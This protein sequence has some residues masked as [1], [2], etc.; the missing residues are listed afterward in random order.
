MKNWTIDDER[1]FKHHHLGQSI[2]PANQ[3]QFVYEKF[4]QYMVRGYLNVTTWANCYG[5]PIRSNH[6]ISLALAWTTAFGANLQGQP[7]FTPF[8]GCS[9]SKVACTD[10]HL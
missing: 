1:L 9:S 3:K 4:G 5:W 2:W 6:F 7:I 8:D 10:Y